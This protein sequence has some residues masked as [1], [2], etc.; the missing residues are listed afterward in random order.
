MLSSSLAD[1]V[2]FAALPS[3]RAA[4]AYT[5]AIT[6]TNVDGRFEADDVSLL[7]LFGRFALEH[8]WT[9]VDV[10]AIRNELGESGL[11]I[12]YEIDGRIY[13]EVDKFAEF[14]ILRRDREPAGKIPTIRGE[15][16]ADPPQVRRESAADPP[17]V[18]RESAADPPQ[19]RRESAADPPRVRDNPPQKF[20]RSRREVE[21]EVEA[22]ATTTT[23]AHEVS[24]ELEATRL[25]RCWKI[26]HERINEKRAAKNQRSVIPPPADYF[27]ATYLAALG[28]SAYFPADE[29]LVDELSRV[30]RC[31]AEK[32]YR[33]TFRSVGKQIGQRFGE[34]APAGLEELPPAEGSKGGSTI[35]AGVAATMPDVP[36]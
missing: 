12:V 33:V 34:S 3:E 6:K 28:S 13:V 16:A 8:E 11:W 20:K 24:H 9:K 22:G 23:S 14:N 35:A 4:L 7:V 25:V 31:L 19:V 26:V 36:S 29:E 5:L 10:A 18:R 30:A 2:R 1:S 32:G 21:E 15:S 17:Q 27:E